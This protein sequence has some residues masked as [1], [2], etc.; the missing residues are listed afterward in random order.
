MKKD[1]FESTLLDSGALL[2]QSYRAVISNMGKIIAAITLAVAA[3]VTFTEIGFCDIS[4]QKFTSSLI[5]MLIASHVIYFSL[6]N[7]GERLGEESEEYLSCTQKYREIRARV[8]C[9]MIS[10]LRAFLAEYTHAELEY[11]KSSRLLALGFSKEVFERSGK[12][13]LPLIQRMRVRAVEKMKPMSITPST[14]L[15]LKATHAKSE[16]FNP[17]RGKI[18]RLC[19]SLLPSTLCMCFTVSVMLTAKDGL[20][21]TEIINGILKLSA[22]PIIGLKGYARGYTYAKCTLPEWIKTKS[23]MLE[24]FLSRKDCLNP[25]QA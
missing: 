10:E 19:L 9:N 8:G 23:E 6:E 22:L 11:R 14:L 16:I 15:S 18:L 20:D 3:L 1:G 13:G 2:H 7:A 12:R 5:L 4:S 25:P 24:T 17:E 21:A